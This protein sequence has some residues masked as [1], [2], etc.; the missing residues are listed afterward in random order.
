MS[1]LVRIFARISRCSM[2]VRC[3]RD[4]S[5][6]FSAWLMHRVCRIFS[7][8]TASISARATVRAGVRL[9]F[10]WW[11]WSWFSQ[12]WKIRKKNR[13]IDYRKFQSIKKSWNWRWKFRSIKKNRWIDVRNPNQ[14][15]KRSLTLM[16]CED[17]CPKVK[18]K[19]VPY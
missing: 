16:A 4:T 6:S 10:L 3:V 1:I 13:E 5:G 11:R 8:G 12:P 18:R 17:R 7:H 15:L 2:R 14:S 9:N 19:L